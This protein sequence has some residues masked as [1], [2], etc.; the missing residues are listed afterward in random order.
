[1]SPSPTLRATS[2]SRLGSMVYEATPSTSDGAMP[3][4]SSAAETAWQASESSVSAKP[5]P[6]AV[7]PMPATAVLSVI[8]SLDDRRATPSPALPLRRPAL[9]ERCDTFFRVFGRGVELDEHRLFFEQIATRQLR[10][11]VQQLLRPADCLG[12]S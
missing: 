11:I 4:S 3:A 6:N 2:T 5:L 7:W 12:R 10:C 8:R 1:M 9:A